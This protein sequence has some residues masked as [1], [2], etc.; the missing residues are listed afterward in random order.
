MS[1][2]PE[3][4]LPPPPSPAAPP[5]AAPPPSDNGLP[6]SEQRQWAMFA[7]LSALIGLIVPFGN[8]LGPLVIWLVQKDKMAFVDDQ[9]KE[10]LNFQITVFGAAVIS[11][12]LMFILIGFLLI[13]GVALGAL[14]LTIIAAIKANEGVAYR[15]PLTIRLI[16]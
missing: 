3:Q 13:F 12:F 9:G 16:K 2:T 7:H 11:F 4:P 8:V 5:P 10:A 6:S 1:D 15:Y 14:V